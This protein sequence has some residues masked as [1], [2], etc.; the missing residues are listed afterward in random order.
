[1]P[2]ERTTKSEKRSPAMRWLKSVGPVP[3]SAM[4]SAESPRRGPTTTS[5]RVAQ[6][7]VGGLPHLAEGER[8][9]KR[10]AAKFDLLKQL[11]AEKSVREKQHG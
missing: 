1:M 7:L 10:L 8:R 2:A 6:R 9:V 4:A 11:A 5:L 3:T